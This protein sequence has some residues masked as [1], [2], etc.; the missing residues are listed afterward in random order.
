MI[1]LRVA[2]PSRTPSCCRP[3]PGTCPP[4]H[5]GV[6]CRLA[7]EVCEAWQ[8]DDWVDVCIGEQPRHA[9]HQLL[10]VLAERV[11]GSTAQPR[12]LHL[13]LH[14][15]PGLHGQVHGSRGGRGVRSGDGAFAALRQ[16]TGG[17][18]WAGGRVVDEAA[19]ALRLL[20]LSLPQLL[21]PALLPTLP[22]SSR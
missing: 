22:P 9:R 3:Y 19:A 1:R 14:Q 18:G 2:S 4:S 6:A 15:L 17:G 16:P 12:R 8:L 7:L 5:R 21:L 20:L 13:L 10:K 11:L